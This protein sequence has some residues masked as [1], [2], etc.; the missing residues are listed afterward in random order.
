MT[1]MFLNDNL[2]IIN[3]DNILNGW[4]SQSLQYSV[5]F[6][7][8]YSQYSIAGLSARNDTLIGVY[9]WSINDGGPSPE[10]I[11]YNT[12]IFFEANTFIDGTSFHDDDTSFSIPVNVTAINV[13]GLSNL[14]QCVYNVNGSEYVCGGP[15]T[16]NLTVLSNEYNYSPSGFVDGIY[17]VNAT[18]CDLSDVC[19]STET[20]SFIIYNNTV[21][22]NAIVGSQQ[23][24]NSLTNLL[25]G[26]IVVTVL[27][28][29][30][31][32]IVLVT[33]VEISTT[34]LWVIGLTLVGL[35]I[36]IMVLSF[37]VMAKV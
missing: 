36:T 31:A 9:G 8:G 19:V 14:T 24:V 25:V 17:H 35:L 18:A 37:N 26:L 6:D 32:G 10:V 16:G 11:V 7:A 29:I 23:A 12:S 13:N 27:I 3:Y 1:S 15:A 33:G 2:S 28:G 21:V 5:P 30:I 22:D 20:R 34:M 4:A